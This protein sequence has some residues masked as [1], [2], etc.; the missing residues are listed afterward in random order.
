MV[1]KIHT[2]NHS[3]EKNE[4]KVVLGIAIANINQSWAAVTLSYSAT[5]QTAAAA[6]QPTFK[7][8][9]RYAKKKSGH[10][11]GKFY[12]VRSQ[13]LVVAWCHQ[14][15]NHPPLCYKVKALWNWKFFAEEETKRKKSVIL[16]HSG[17][18]I[19]LR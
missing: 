19:P 18:R 12:Q 3:F 7:P 8:A 15:T 16:W 2:P 1:R 5:L 4:I 17:A 10:D 9:K 6:T 14:P 13:Q 11:P